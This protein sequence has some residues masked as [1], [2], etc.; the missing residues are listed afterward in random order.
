MQ[1]PTAPQKQIIFS[2]IQPSGTPTLGNYI[3]AMRH[4]QR[5]Q[6]DYRCIYC[7]VDLHTLTVRQSPAA[8]RKQSLEMLA[9]LLAVGLDPAQTV[10][11]LQSHV[12]GHAEL[13]WVL[14]CYTYMGELSRMTQFK[15][16]SARHADN[17]NA[18]LFAYPVLMAADILLYQA[19]LVPVGADQK[20]HV[21]IC[22]DVALRFNGL[23]PGAFTV[24]EPYIAPNG[25]RVYSLQDP[26]HKMSKSDAE[27]TYISLLDRPDVVRRKI[28]RAV[29]DSDGEIRYDPQTKPGVSNLLTIL[30]A[31]QGN[32]V[33]DCAAALAGMGY[34]ALKD[35]VAQTV[36]DTLSPMQARFDALMADKP[37]LEQ[38]LA[39]GADQA[40]RIAR[41]TLEKVY[42]KVGLCPRPR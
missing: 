21:E 31:L 8:L 7:V 28:K 32:S 29:T 1:E 37:Y 10:L 12:S 26:A 35:A 27:D 42:K 5:M 3:G 18:G 39:Q 20:Q 23:Y 40:D 17:I 9:L 2:G 36:V 41:R 14:S 11:F 25:A 24:P 22:R 16:K 6:Q 19:H 30:A 38:V 34:G 4:W 33:A 15:E 13:N